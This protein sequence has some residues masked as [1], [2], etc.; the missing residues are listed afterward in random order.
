MI[1]S[2]LLYLY[3]AVLKKYKFHAYF[4]T[5]AL[6]FYFTKKADKM[7]VLF[8]K[9]CAVDKNTRQESFP[10]V[11]LLVVKACFEKYSLISIPNPNS[12]L[13]GEELCLK[14]G[15]FDCLPKVLR[16]T[17][18]TEQATLNTRFNLVDI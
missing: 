15:H 12:I 13:L 5:S 17:K 7:Q 2:L 10:A 3:E 6:I 14:Q 4:Y 9:K 11:C 18:P 8:I 1:L 16:D